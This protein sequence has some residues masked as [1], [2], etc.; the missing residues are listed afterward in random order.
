[1]E[2]RG[3]PRQ[4]AHVGPEPSSS[5][6]YF[7]DITI[8]LNA[9]QASFLAGAAISQAHHAPQIANNAADVA[10]SSQLE[11]Q[12][13]QRVAN[14]IHP[15]LRPKH[16]RDKFVKPVISSPCK[17]LYGHPD[18]GG[19]WEQQ[20]KKIIKNSGGQE[21]PEYPGNSFFPETKLLLSTHVDDLTLAGP[22]EEHEPFCASRLNPFTES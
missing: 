8:D 18:A 3:R 19:L 17:A 13:A 4:R 7:P 5:S 14:A 9:T 10:L 2:E 1:M 16:W 11:V 21:I 20:P 22:T 15:E 6:G 12:H